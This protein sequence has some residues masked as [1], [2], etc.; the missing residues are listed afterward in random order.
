MALVA[1]RHVESSWTR[2]ELVSLE[3]QGGFLATRPPGKP[4]NIH[5]KMANFVNFIL[6]Q[7][8]KMGL[9]KAREN[10]KFGIVV[11]SCLGRKKGMG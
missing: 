1:P 3:L 9:K 5:F 6:P 7:K 10:M 4:Q 2:I 8:G 11:T